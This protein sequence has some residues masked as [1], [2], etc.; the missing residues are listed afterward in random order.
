M[1]DIVSMWEKS[2]LQAFQDQIDD[3]LALQA[4]A[5]ILPK[6]RW[7]KATAVFVTL[8]CCVVPAVAIAATNGY[9]DQPS[10]PPTAEVK[11]NAKAVEPELLYIT[12]P[13][14]VVVGV[15]PKKVTHRGPGT[16]TERIIRMYGTKVR[17]CGQ[18]TFQ[19]PERT[20]TDLSQNYR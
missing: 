17:A 3:E 1:S 12:V 5:S 9:F 16:C 19:I 14:V 20:A 15:S 2:E 7:K 6:N 4:L 10:K 18:P 11:L 13:E 8:A